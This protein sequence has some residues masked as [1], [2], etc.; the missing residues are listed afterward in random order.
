[1]HGGGGGGGRGD[2]MYGLHFFGDPVIDGG[3]KVRSRP[4]NITCPCL[5]YQEWL[6][7]RVMHPNSA[8]GKLDHD[9]MRKK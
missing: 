7:Y 4:A 1:M 5:S 9:K 2:T 3:R 6:E 8:L